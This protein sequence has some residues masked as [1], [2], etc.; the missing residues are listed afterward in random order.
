MDLLLHLRGRI[1][2]T[3]SLQQTLED[4]VDLET[5]FNAHL[6]FLSQRQGPTGAWV[7]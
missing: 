4:K 3:K 2:G 1:I 5:M 6:E 7:T